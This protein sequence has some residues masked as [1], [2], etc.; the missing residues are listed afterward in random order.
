MIEEHYFVK[1]LQYWQN[2]KHHYYILKMQETYQKKVYEVLH[3][4]YYCEISSIQMFNFII[5]Q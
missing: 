3:R 5:Q 1:V 4:L 2:L